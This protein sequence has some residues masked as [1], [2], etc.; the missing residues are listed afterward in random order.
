MKDKEYTPH[1]VEEQIAYQNG[2]EFAIYLILE[3]LS[4]HQE[5]AL[6][7]VNNFIHEVKKEIG[8]RVKY[9]RKEW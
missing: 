2:F 9:I 4:N 3:V 7:T 1:T 5:K 8:V 6:F